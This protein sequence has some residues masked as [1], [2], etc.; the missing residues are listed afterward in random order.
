LKKC[1][2][3]GSIN[4]DSD[5]SCGVCGG[6]VSGVIPRDLLFLKAER[7]PLVQPK[8]QVHPRA[9]AILGAGLSTTALGLYL[10]FA[11]G[12]VGLFLMLAGVTIV[13]AVFGIEGSF[14]GTMG[15]S[16]ASTEYRERRAKERWDKERE[17]Q[18]RGVE[19]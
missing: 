2:N 7:P 9:I 16:T 8:T 19:E 18:E 3:C 13:A 11:S 12:V 4:Q 1:P 15:R 6:D 5:L 14:T 10:L 17:N